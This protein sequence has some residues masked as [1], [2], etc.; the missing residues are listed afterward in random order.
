[1]NL[2][3]WIA[4]ATA[5][6]VPAAALCQ[7]EPGQIRPG[8]ALDTAFIRAGIDSLTLLLEH[9]GDTVRA[10]TWIMETV[11]DTVA[12]GRRIVQVQRLEL[13]GGPAT[14][15]DSA[16]LHWQTLVP[17]SAHVRGPAPYDYFFGP[18]GVRI[19][20]LRNSIS[21]EVA[22][23]SPVFHQGTLDLL[24]RALPL[25]VGYRAVLPVLMPHGAQGQ[26][27]VA[28][29]GEEDVR[30]LD[31]G[32]CRSLVVETREDD[33]EGTYRVATATRDLVRYDSE[34]TIAVRPVGCP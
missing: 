12:G 9:E 17:I 18:P 22:L 5:L 34:Y 25:R 4:L 14:V 16:H 23:A 28:V 26:V 2:F 6:A 19:A 3:R 21:R 24:L 31:G 10:G 27:H 7:P 33:D 13:G 15:A 1:M 20:S 11:L 32:S 8:T 29:T 30:T